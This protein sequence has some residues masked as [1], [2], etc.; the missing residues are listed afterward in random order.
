M[1][2]VEKFEQNLK[3]ESKTTLNDFSIL[4]QS[5]DE[6]SKYCFKND[7]ELGL[8]GWS[9]NFNLIALEPAYLSYTKIIKEFVEKHGTR[10]DNQIK[11][12]HTSS[13][14]K[15]FL[16][17]DIELKNIEQELP[18]LKKIKWDKD[19]KIPSRMLIILQRYGLLDG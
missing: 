14:G 13:R 11:I 6:I 19:L 4:Y 3:T 8:S 7:I 5:L 16:E 12:D 17:L 15:E 9:I 10:K 18:D 1:N 2:V